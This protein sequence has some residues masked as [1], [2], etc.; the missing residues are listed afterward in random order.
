MENVAIEIVKLE[1]GVQITT[2]SDDADTI[3]RMHE[4]A[5]MHLL[6]QSIE[7]T[8][9]NLDN[10]VEITITSD[11]PD[12]VDMIQNRDMPKGPRDNEDITVEQVDIANGVRITITTDNADLVEKIQ[13]HGAMEPHD[14]PRRRHGPR[15]DKMD[16]EDDDSE[17]S[18]S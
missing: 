3:T 6:K 10:G 17:S 8:V 11:N 12:A 1:N 9:T 15:G 16:L 13:E 18:A 5:D 2:T 4:M 7:R 14:H